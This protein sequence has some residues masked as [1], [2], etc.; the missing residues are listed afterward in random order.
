M[1]KI[2]K[3][4]DELAQEVEQDGRTTFSTCDHSNWDRD[5]WAYRRQIVHELPGYTPIP[6]LEWLENL[7]PRSQFAILGCRTA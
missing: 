7:V 1:E 4:I 3:F 6:F 5:K 2:L